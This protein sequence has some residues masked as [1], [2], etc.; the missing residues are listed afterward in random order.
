MPRASGTLS[1]TMSPQAAEPA[2]GDA[3]IGRIGL[4]KRFEGGL[5]GEV[6]GQGEAG[7]RQNRGGDARRAGDAHE[8]P[9]LT[10]DGTVSRQRRLSV[11]LPS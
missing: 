2:V 11:E 6:R 5:R 7:A 1:V 10:R 8:R 4:H 9:Y 3:S